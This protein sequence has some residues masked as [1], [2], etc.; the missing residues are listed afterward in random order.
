MFE[1]TLQKL[2]GVSLKW[3]LLIPFLFFAFAGTTTLTVI[4]LTSQQQL[5]KR[6]ERG[7]LLLHYQNFQNA[8]ERKGRQAA[9]LATV[10]AENQDV[11]RLMRMRDR[12]GLNDLLVHTYVRLAIEYDISQFHFH[13]P[14]GIS[15]LRLHSPKMH[16]D[17]IA[18]YRETVTQAVKRCRPVWGLEKGETGFGIRG[19]VPVFCGTKC[20]GS[21]EIG[22]DFG[23]SFLESLHRRWNIDLA[24][25]RRAADGTYE[26]M[27]SVSGD[28]DD[29]V[30]FGP[31]TLGH[32]HTEPTLLIA[33]KG[34]QDRAILLS[35]VRDYGGNRVA[36]V[37]IS[38]DR[39]L[40]RQRLER[41]RNVMVLVGALGIAVSFVLTYLVAILYIRPIKKIVHEARDIADEK[42]ESYLE[43]GLGD[44]IGTL[45]L[46]LNR[47]LA[48]L[49]A[50][51]AQ[52]E[53]YAKNLEKRVQERT[54]DLV[55]S[56]EKYRTLVE[57]VPLI[58]YRLLEDGTTE[59]INSCLTE[60]LGY[61]IE[62][63]V[64]NR[65]FWRE[66][67]LG[68]DEA[69]YRKLF[70]T[71]FIKGK[72]YRIERVVQNKD[73]RPLVFLDHAIPAMGEHG[74][75]LWI[76]GIMMDIT[77][78]KQLQQRALRTEETRLL[79][80]I[81]ARM[82]HEIRNPLATVGGFARRLRD[83]LPEEDRNRKMAEIIVQ[84]VARM[85]TFLRI[86]LNSIRPFELSLSEVSVNQIL[87][88]WLEELKGLM[89]SRE[90]EVEVQFDRNL[91]EVMADE[92]RL[93]EAFASLLKHAVVSMCEGDTLQVQTR[94]S[95]GYIHVRMAFQGQHISGDD[96]EH[97]FFP[98]LEKDPEK[99]VLD[100]P[101][102][103]IIVHR[104]GGSI[105]VFRE[106]DLL[107]TNIDL[108]V[109]PTGERVE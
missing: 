6:E 7:K 26:P 32:A 63:A 87:R 72:E 36:L 39:S 49:M 101:L 80:E 61:A 60:C 51:R 59:F 54:A 79:G 35:P 55:A 76:D 75:V 81:S 11:Q 12:K 56:E 93:N 92:E 88:S 105:E 41:S 98:H 108:P 78:L 24:L 69:A 57:A 65:D 1:R 46:S 70:G 4:G 84:E 86:L 82:A 85:E 14:S 100:L 89:A 64:G 33:P 28:K 13:T 52:I 16:G 47:M 22:Q 27:A 94:S 17:D 38:E 9:A 31:E 107:V 43:P 8:L 40:I 66:K 45:T 99:S 106:K 15:F 10:V 19:V 23:E 2:Q 21:V 62:E 103:K 53:G 30:F 73:G 96:L 68:N 104:H 48:S 91:P 58:V 74:Q 50:R 18:S 20:F 5:I 102:S 42:R 37:E 109:R 34:L 44:E 90:I 67:I 95:N 97:F 71:C 77:E 29:Q 3:K 83:A 25:Y